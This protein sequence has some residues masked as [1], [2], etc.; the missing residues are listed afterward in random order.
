M[1]TSII[2]DNSIAVEKLIPREYTQYI[3]PPLF[4]GRY[5][6]ASASDDFHYAPHQVTCR[7]LGVLQY[8][9]GNIFCSVPVGAVITSLTCCGYAFDVNS[10][11]RYILYEGDDTDTGAANFWGRWA[12]T[13][14]GIIGDRNATW[15]PAGG[16]T[17]ESGTTYSLQVEM[18]VQGIVA[19][20]QFKGVRIIYEF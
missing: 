4:T 16:W 7:N 19:N 11:I 5:E 10:V 20:L 14:A 6:D 3:G 13:P 2:P 15:T 12:A 9:Q 18:T 1:P 8:L 17:V